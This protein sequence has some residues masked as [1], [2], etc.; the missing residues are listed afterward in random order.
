MAMNV[1]VGGMYHGPGPAR[2]NDMMA[3]GMGAQNSQQQQISVNYG[4][5]RGPTE[6]PYDASSF[7][8]LGGPRGYPVQSGGGP[9]PHHSMGIGG[10]NAVH[11]RDEEFTIHNDADF[12]ALPGSNS[13]GIKGRG[14][15]SGSMGSEEGERGGDSGSMGRGGEQQQVQYPPGSSGRGG[16]MSNAGQ[17]IQAQHQGGM[18]VLGSG[19]GAYGPMSQTQ[20][21]GQGQ[22]ST[23]QMTHPPS[24]GLYPTSNVGGSQSSAGSSAAF[25]GGG[26]GGVINPNSLTPNRPTSTYPIASPGLVSSSPR[27]QQGSSSIPSSSSVDQSAPTAV[28]TGDSKYGLL[29]LLDVIRLTDRV[30]GRLSA[31]YTPSF[32]PSLPCFALL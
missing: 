17:I 12:P 31:I 15:H 3:G 19:G 18:A 11:T 4:V 20:G 5:P 32:P 1:G 10:A 2:M 16:V 23:S 22:V 26:G 30:R 25:S 14:D 28:A 24:P 9:S 13:S 21:Q 7:P 6:M 8:V 29:G 27:H